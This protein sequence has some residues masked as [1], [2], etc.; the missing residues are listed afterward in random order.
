M[1]QLKNVYVAYDADSAGSKIG[2]A[3][4][5]DDTASISEVSARIE[6]G[7]ELFRKWA[8]QEYDGQCYSS[9]GDQ[10]LFSIK[11]E[12]IEHLEEIRRDYEFATD[13]TLSIGV[14]QSAS[15]AGKA[16]L[17]AKFR[18]KN[19]VVMYD[20]SVENDIQ[21]TESR[22][23]VGQGSDEEKKLGDAY[24]SKDPKNGYLQDSWQQDQI[25]KEKTGQS[26]SQLATES[27]EQKADRQKEDPELQSPQDAEDKI[28]HEAS[29]KVYEDKKEDPNKLPDKQLDKQKEEEIGQA[30]RHVFAKEN[31]TP[32]EKEESTGK[33]PSKDEFKDPEGKERDMKTEDKPNKEKKDEKGKEIPKE[34]PQE[35]QEVIEEVGEEV[36]QEHS[37]VCPACG[38]AQEESAEV[39]E[40]NIEDP[41]QDEV[42]QAD[43]MNDVDNAN[44]PAGQEME[45]NVSRPEGFSEENVPGDLGMG[46]GPEGGVE[47]ENGNPEDTQDDTWGQANPQDEEPPMQ[48][49][50]QDGLEGGAEDA[51]AEQVK[52]MIGQA[53]SGFKNNK[54][55]LEQA[56]AQ[57][58]E[59]YSSCISMLRAMIEMAK[60]LGLSDGSEQ[61]PEQNG[62][63]SQMPGQE[64]PCPTCG[65]GAQEE[66]PSKESFPP[67]KDSKEGFPK[68]EDDKEAKPE[69]KGFPPKKDDKK[70][71]KSAAPKEGAANESPKG[72]K[73]GG[74]GLGKLPTKAT[75]KHTAR[76]PL[77]EGSINLKGQQKTVDKKTGKT[78]WINR[79][80]AVVMGPSGVPVKENAQ[81]QRKNN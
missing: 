52:Q 27:L 71:D 54:Q 43:E 34:A 78:R 35:G 46:G 48:S 50:M 28:S 51:Q 72:S 21:Q 68:K 33:D 30:D 55:V 36:P 7:N 26:P 17:A 76:T 3:I 41:P 47:I 8:E 58:P 5:S 69:G 12:A 32:R 74:G 15:Q 49:V 61:M 44:M 2:R 29:A 56:K 13:L 19:Q 45:G 14:G 81:E 77:M 57:A 66:Q 24:L 37:E 23:S 22:L 39:I 73:P 11:P 53:L 20:D 9:G 42:V 62:A 6:L 38:K 64:Q 31:S 75:T 70:E 67:K 4:L 10:G 65:H 79:K 63:D 25:A 60:M 40:E 80:K 16:L 59:L 1:D 18:G